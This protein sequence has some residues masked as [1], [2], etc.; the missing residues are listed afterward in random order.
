MLWASMID[1]KRILCKIASGR[2]EDLISIKGLS[3]AGKIK[4][5]IDRCFTLE[6]TAEAHW[7]VENGYKKRKAVNLKCSISQEVQW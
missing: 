2:V 4:S 1:S 5:I 7:Y 6:Q 3:E